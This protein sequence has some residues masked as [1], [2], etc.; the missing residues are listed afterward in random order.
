MLALGVYLEWVHPDW[1]QVHPITA[2][3]ISS[4]IGFC[5]VTAVVGVVLTALSHRRD[6]EPYERRIVEAV[7]QLRYNLSWTPVVTEKMTG[8]MRPNAGVVR[9][10]ALVINDETVEM[11]DGL[12]QVLRDEADRLYRYWVRPYIE[13][14]L[15]AAG[16]GPFDLKDL[17]DIEGEL[18]RVNDL[19]TLKSDH[20]PAVDNGV[21][22]FRDRLWRTEVRALVAS[23]YRRIAD[24]METF[25]TQ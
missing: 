1:L 12:L 7:E 17:A 15:I 11:P 8:A 9:R 13:T 5:A 10:M 18:Q 21:E 22:E 24:V 25:I 23:L 19:F 14:H 4:M 16:S 6:R 2:N 20:R 3:L